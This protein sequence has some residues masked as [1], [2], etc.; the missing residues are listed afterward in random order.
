MGFGIP[1]QEWI[2]TDLNEWAEYLLSEEQNKKHNIFDFDQLNSGWLSHKEGK[3]NNIMKLWPII[4]FNQ[5]Y[6][7]YISN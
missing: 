1:V 5:W 4:Q 7:H 6:N 2:K 3:H